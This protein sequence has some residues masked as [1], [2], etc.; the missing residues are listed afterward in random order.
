MDDRL[1]EMTVFVRVAESGSLSR[2]ARELALSQP[3]VSR[4]I[5]GWRRG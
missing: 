2:A 4:I 5:G 3:S 1:Q